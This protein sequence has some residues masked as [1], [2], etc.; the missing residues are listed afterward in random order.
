MTGLILNPYT[1]LGHIYVLI[2]IFI[3][4][5]K[6][7]EGEELMLESKTA[8]SLLIFWLMFGLT[9]ILLIILAVLINGTAL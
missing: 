9:I 6:K 1:M 4:S 3:K 8:R 2:P 5:D 7:N